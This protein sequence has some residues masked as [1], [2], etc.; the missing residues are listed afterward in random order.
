MEHLVQLFPSCTDADLQRHLD[1]AAG[2]LEVAINTILESSADQE[3]SAVQLSATAP[4]QH[5]KRQKQYS[6]ET[7]EVNGHSTE[8]WDLTL[9]SDGDDEDN[10]DNEGEWYKGTTEN[11]DIFISQQPGIAIAAGSSSTG[12]QKPVAS[13]SR[14]SFEDFHNEQQRLLEEQARKAAEVQEQKNKLVANF[15]SIAQDMFENISVPYLE[16]L[17][18]ETRP[19]F[20][21]DDELVDACIEIIFALN[22]RYPKAKRKRLDDDDDDDEGEGGGSEPYN[23]GDEY[24]GGV[25][26]DGDKNISKRQRDYMNCTIRMSA[27]YDAQSAIQLYQDFPRIAA[28]SIRSCLK[29]FSFHYAPTFEYLNSLWTEFEPKGSQGK[30]KAGEIKIILVSVPRK[31]RPPLEPQGMDPEFRREMDWMKAKV[32]KELAEIQTIENEEKNTNYYRD[33]GELWLLLR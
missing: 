18:E 17:L 6:V 28:S 19:R 22:G 33:R 15:I 31:K 30:A 14:P 23:E 1:N 5:H 4:N 16:R 8:V 32:A 24:V 13:D 27:A 21:S 9:D 11:L 10:H 26:G 20:L 3:S 29:K 2:N 25:A 12:P 7:I